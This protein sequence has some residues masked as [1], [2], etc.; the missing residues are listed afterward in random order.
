MISLIII[1][2]ILV[3]WFGFLIWLALRARRGRISV[4]TPLGADYELFNKDQ[5]KSVEVIVKRAAGEKEEDRSS[6][7]P[8]DPGEAE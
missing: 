4:T 7:D 2:A 1:I 5:R 3:V 8:P 6:S